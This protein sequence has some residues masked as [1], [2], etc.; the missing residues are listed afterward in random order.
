VTDPRR[1]RVRVEGVVQGVGFRPHVH[2]LATDLGLAGFVLNDASGVL[3]E[4]EAPPAA[5]ERFLERLGAEAPPLASIE[6]LVPEELAP[7]G[8]RGFA[9]LVS[10]GAGEPSA[11]VAPDAAT[12]ADCLAE[13]RDPA[14]RRH[15]YPFINCTACGPRY[16]IVTGVPY[17]R[18]RTTMAGF[19]MC[20]LCRAEYADPAD[21]RFHAEPIACPAC[22]PS[23]RLIDA[24]G[25]AVPGDPVAVAAAALLDG[26][27]VAV[28]GIGGFHLACRAADEG[29]VAR[30][31]ARKRREEKPFAVMVPDVA[32]AHLLVSLSPAEGALLA[33]RERP[34]VLARR[35]TGAAVAPSVAPRS[36]D[37]GVMLPYSPLHHLLLEDAGTP[38]VMTSGNLSDEPIAHRD[39]DA[40]ERLGPV[41]DLLLLHDRPIHTRVDDSVVRAVRGRRPLLM[42]RSRGW[43]PASLALPVPAERPLLACGAQLKST[44]C[45]AKGHRAWVGHHIGDLEEWETLRAFR[46]SAEH[47]ERLFAVTPEVVAHDLH[48]GYLSTAYALER[49][50]VETLA[51]QH[52]HAHLAACLAEWGERGPAVG[53][54][55]DGTGYG[56]DG[57]IWGGEILVGGL[58]DARRVA[59]LW[60]VR[61]PGGEAA[62]RE[63]WRMAC[64]W[65]AEAGAADEPPIPAGIAGRVAPGTWSAVARLARSDRSPVTT[66]AGRLLDAVSAICGLRARVTYEGQAAI[67]LEAACEPAAHGAYPMDGLDPREAILA[68]VRDLA[69]GVAVGVVAARVHDGLAA[70]AAAACERA[71]EDAGTGLVVLSGGVFQNRRLL[72]VTASR[73]ERAGLR[74]L[75]PERLPPNDGGI[76]YGQAAVAAAR[77]ST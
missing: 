68:A 70:A 72:T 19:A 57:T 75:I 18:A 66:S 33:G 8:E 47:L 50:G 34:I 11:A 27:I 7:M 39:E 1:V 17:D 71:A 53:A 12:C 56:T 24:G 22:G 10:D 42:R 13:L 60:P 64:A 31:R 9:I 26:R 51:V 21:R 25:G 36:A 58:R 2:R 16:T 48:P 29:A 35:R 74:V 54:I 49:D 15:R 62:I 67:E 77:G 32:T 38:L 40:R 41:A 4:V 23:A 61:M 73:L 28:K 5:V 52:H 55:L 30:L 45:V 59:H 65:L 14:D 69:G 37:L 44:A 46:E 63:P 6:R 20:D 43:V 3:L 76:S